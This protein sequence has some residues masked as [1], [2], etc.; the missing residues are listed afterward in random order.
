MIYPN[1]TPLPTSRQCNLPIFKK[2]VYTAEKFEI[3]KKLYRLYTHKE[4]DRW[5]KIWSLLGAF[6]MNVGIVYL[7]SRLFSFLMP[8]DQKLESVFI[9]GNYIVQPILNYVYQS[10]LGPEASYFMLMFFFGCVLAPI[11]EE[12]VFRKF[13]YDIW[14]RGKSEEYKKR[15]MLHAITFSSILFGLAH[16]SVANLLMQGVAG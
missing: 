1:G 9:G 13:V 2:Q 10:S 15:Y 11:W 16:G 8:E 5:G 3:M 12:Y 7:V 4:S 14:I 6:I